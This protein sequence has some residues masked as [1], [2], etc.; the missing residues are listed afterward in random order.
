MGSD[1][2]PTITRP[3]PRGG[4]DQQVWLFSNGYGASV[5]RHAFTQGLE[6]GVIRQELNEN[7]WDFRLDYT[8][9]IAPDA[10]I[11]YCTDDSVQEI[12]IRIKDLPQVEGL[13][14]D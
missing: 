3:C 6:L 8:T 2:A 1:V 5:I 11:G 12:I 7:P 10:I 14:R 4:D 13:K 9:L